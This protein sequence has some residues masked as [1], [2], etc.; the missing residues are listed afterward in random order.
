MLSLYTTKMQ[1]CLVSSLII[2]IWRPSPRQRQD[3]QMQWLC[4]LYLNHMF[5]STEC[6]IK[7]D[8][9][10]GVIELHTTSNLTVMRA[11]KH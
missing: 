6:L 10:C 3:V 4:G 8:L 7:M 1:G 2:E 5:R 9:T 11:S